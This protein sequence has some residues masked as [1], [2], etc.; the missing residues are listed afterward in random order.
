MVSRVLK[1]IMPFSPGRD[2]LHH[3]LLDLGIKPKKI[4]VIFIGASSLLAL[5]GFL[6]EI[7]FENK[8]YISFYAFLSL[9]LFYYFLSKKEII[10]NV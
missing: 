10:K 7:N 8:E 1:G 2:H 3:K 9:S 6:I 4:L 5:I